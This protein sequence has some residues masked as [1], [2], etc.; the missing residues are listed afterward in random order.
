MHINK[1]MKLKFV[2]ILALTLMAGA[3]THAQQQQV[4]PVAV[5]D[6]ESK[7]ENVSD[8]GPKVAALVN[9]NLSAEPLPLPPGEVLLSSGPVDGALPPDTTAW[10]TA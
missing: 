9:A 2:S 3:V 6:F 4:L 8:L 1:I 10:L 7:D 5:F